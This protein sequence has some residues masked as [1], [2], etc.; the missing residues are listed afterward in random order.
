MRPGEKYISLSSL[1]FC[2]LLLFLSDGNVVAQGNPTQTLQTQDTIRRQL[3]LEDVPVVP[4]DRRSSSPFF[5]EMPSNFSRTAIYDPV[6][7]EYIIYQK[8]GGLD[9]SEERRGG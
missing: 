2:L 3:K 6:K 8:V 4:W 1:L 9:R 5:L 7:N